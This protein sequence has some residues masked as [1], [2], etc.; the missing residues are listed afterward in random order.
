MSFWN[1]TNTERKEVSIIDTQCKREKK[2]RGMENKYFAEKIKEQIGF[3]HS[4]YS[5]IS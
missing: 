2:I 1:G 5:Q 4:S 3:N